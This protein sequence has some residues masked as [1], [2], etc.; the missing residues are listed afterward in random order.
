MTHFT[1]TYSSESQLPLVAKQIMFYAEEYRVW[2]FEGEMG[3]GKTTIIKA[4]CKELKVTDNVQSPTFSLVNEYRTED[5]KTCYHFD[6]Y[7][8]KDESEAMDIGYEEYFYS[9]NYCF[10]EW[11]AKIPSLLPAKYLK[12]NINFVNPKQRIIHLSKH[13]QHL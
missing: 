13:E 12:I 6:F 10:V 4:I 1:L 8:I 3:V 7:R 9:G 5:G 11:P 2:L